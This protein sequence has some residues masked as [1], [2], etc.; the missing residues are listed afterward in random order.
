MRK[1]II[2]F[3]NRLLVDRRR[4]T[5]PNDSMISNQL[6]HAVENEGETHAKHDERENDENYNDML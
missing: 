6:P 4:F 2:V 1:H 5:Y 3:Y